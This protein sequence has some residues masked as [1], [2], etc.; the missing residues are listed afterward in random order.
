MTPGYIVHTMHKSKVS[1]PAIWG[2]SKGRFFGGCSKLT[3]FPSLVFLAISNPE[4]I[5]R[6]GVVKTRAQ[7]VFSSSNFLNCGLKM[8]YV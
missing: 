2:K 8:R 1:E 7:N 4:K 6:K 5:P 3:F